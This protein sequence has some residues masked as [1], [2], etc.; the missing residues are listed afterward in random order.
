MLRLHNPALFGKLL[1]PTFVV[2]GQS[3]YVSTSGEEEFSGPQ[4]PGASGLE[5]DE[6]SQNHYHL[7]DIF[8]HD[9]PLIEKQGEEE[10]DEHHEDFVRAWEITKQLAHVWATALREKF[11]GEEFIV[12]ATK[13]SG[14]DHPVFPS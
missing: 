12:V 3:F 9:V 10:F 1:W 8:E 2:K 4:N 5:L 13:M 6:W 7:F 11:P 14:P